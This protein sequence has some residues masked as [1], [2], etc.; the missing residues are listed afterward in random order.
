MRWMMVAALLWAGPASAQGVLDRWGAL[1]PPGPAPV[2]KAVQLEPATTALL[3]LDLA[4]QT[5]TA[6]RRCPPMLPAVADLLARARARHWT[7]IYTIGAGVAESDILAPVAKL[8]EEAV[9]S[10]P[11]DKFVGTALESMLKAHGIRTVVTVGSAAEGAVL[12]TAAAAAFR[13]FAVVLPVDGMASASD[14]ALQYVA[15]DLTHAPRL[16]DAVTLS[17]LGLVN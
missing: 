11:P 17:A 2:A 9:V 12:E 15:W 16:G 4:R 3:V 10:G 8:A 14:Y 6:E 1:P 5:C 7:V 13:G